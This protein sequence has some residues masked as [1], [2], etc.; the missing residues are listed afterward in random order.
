MFLNRS[1]LIPFL[2][3]FFVLHIG[4]FQLWVS[5][6]KAV[7]AQSF[8]RD[9]W[10]PWKSSDMTAGLEPNSSTNHNL[11]SLSTLTHVNSISFCYRSR[12]NNDDDWCFYSVCWPF[13]NIRSVYNHN[14]QWLAAEENDVTTNPLKP[15]GNYMNH[16]L[17]QSVTLHSVFA[18]FVWFWA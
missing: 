9:W 6:Y 13:E 7:I 10:K 17:H 2:D 3:T 1:I 5:I 8:R 15:T 16:L 18:G 14:R 11:A 12:M 4:N